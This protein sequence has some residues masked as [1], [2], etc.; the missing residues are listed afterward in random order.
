MNDHFIYKEFEIRIEPQIV[1][2]S[3]QYEDL[4]TGEIYETGTWEARQDL[5]AY[6]KRQINL[7]RANE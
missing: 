5:V 1:G 3:G 7:L 6:I 4:R 2:W